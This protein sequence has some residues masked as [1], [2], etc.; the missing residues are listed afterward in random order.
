MG[1]WGVF[2]GPIVASCLHALVQIFNTELKEFSKERFAQTAVGG[3]SAAVTTLAVESGTVVDGN[4]APTQKPRTAAAT[5][6]VEPTSTPMPT[7]PTAA[8]P[9]P[10]RQ[11][12]SVARSSKHAKRSKRGR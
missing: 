6:V 1:L 4:A 5:N 3:V 8:P 7:E 10:P 12:S 9:P 2:V 11:A